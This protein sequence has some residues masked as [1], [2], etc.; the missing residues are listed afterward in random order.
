MPRAAQQLSY[1]RPWSCLG[2]WPGGSAGS[3][4]GG[5]A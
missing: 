4:R 2:A 3:P 5:P 1:G